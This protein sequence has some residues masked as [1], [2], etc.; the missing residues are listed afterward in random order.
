MDIVSVT[1]DGHHFG[2]NLA[3]SGGAHSCPIGR[4]KVTFQAPGKL[5]QP[6]SLLK[7]QPGQRAGHA[8]ANSWQAVA[9]TQHKA[10]HI[11][12][13]STSKEAEVID[14]DRLAPAT[15]RPENTTDTHNDLICGNQG[16]KC[17]NR[18]RKNGEL[19]AS[20]SSQQGLL[21]SSVPATPILQGKMLKHCSSS[22]MP[23]KRNHW[24]IAWV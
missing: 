5:S 11:W 8:A 16:T 7:L 18:G 19:K 10:R 20:E 23:S 12:S 21:S 15:T 9:Q 3:T 2:S 22:G 17:G 6:R 13:F 14:Y 24:H 1:I 4:S